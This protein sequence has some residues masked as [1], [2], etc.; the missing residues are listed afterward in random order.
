[1]DTEDWCDLRLEALFVPSSRGSTLRLNAERIERVS[2]DAPFLGDQLRSLELCR[3]F[4]RVGRGQRGRSRRGSTRHDRDL[5]HDLD[6]AGE[7]DIDDSSFD[8]RI[9]DICR[10]LRRAALSIE[11]T[12]GS[13]HGQASSEPRGTRD[14]HALRAELRDAPTHDLLDLYWVNA[15]AVNRRTLDSSEQFRRVNC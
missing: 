8:H 4:E 12:A 15:R 6:S 2:R 5:T 10:V 3:P 7:G 9:G 11:S 1:M 13:L 14:V